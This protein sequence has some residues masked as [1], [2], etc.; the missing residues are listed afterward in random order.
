MS[1]VYFKV[2]LNGGQAGRLAKLARNVGLTSDELISWCV[3]TGLP[4]L[5]TGGSRVQKKHADA[6]RLLQAEE[7]IE[8]TYGQQD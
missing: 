4:L 6:Y 3:E 8:R 2:R 7:L 1:F 5:E